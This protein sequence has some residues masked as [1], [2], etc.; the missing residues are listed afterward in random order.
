M[1]R[2]IYGD[3][4]HAEVA[5]TLH[6]LG[7][8]CEA[9]GDLVG[10]RRHL[11]ESLRMERAIHGYKDHAEEMGGSRGNFPFGA[12]QWHYSIGNL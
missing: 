11:D 9:E 12:A 4:D 5:A 10:A 3:K 7:R 6:E 2:A 1:K 8:I